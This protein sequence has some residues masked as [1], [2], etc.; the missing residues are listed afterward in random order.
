MKMPEISSFQEIILPVYRGFSVTLK[1]SE[2]GR[3][4]LKSGMEAAAGSGLSFYVNLGP[5]PSQN[6]RF[7]SKPRV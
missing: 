1:L 7:V 5:G 4:Y 3:K 6:F 2:T